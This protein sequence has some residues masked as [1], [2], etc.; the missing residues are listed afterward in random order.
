MA[1]DGA[2]A[3]LALETAHAQVVAGLQPYAAT[4]RANPILGI[5]DHTEEQRIIDCNT[6]PLAD[7]YDLHVRVS[8]IALKG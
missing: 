5:G 6:P 3:S 4:P 7:D 8:C 2:T 1:F